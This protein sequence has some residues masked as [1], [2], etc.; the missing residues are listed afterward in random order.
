FEALLL[1]RG[2]S[3][4]GEGD[5][6]TPRHVELAVA[7]HTFL[8]QRSRVGEVTADGR[9]GTEVTERARLAL[10]VALLA[11]EREHLPVELVGSCGLADATRGAGCARHPC[12]AHLWRRSA[13]R[14]APPGRPPAHLGPLTP[15]P[16]ARS[17]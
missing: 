13:V 3:E 17:P 2:V 1:S 11:R 6:E 5:C 8:E 16:P 9:D 12:G 10:H 14:A 4:V 7:L 15:H